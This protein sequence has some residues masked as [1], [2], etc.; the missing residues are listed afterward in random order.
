KGNYKSILYLEPVDLVNKY[1]PVSDVKPSITPTSSEGQVLDETEILSPLM[2]DNLSKSF[3]YKGKQGLL[4][5]TEDGKYAIETDTEIIEITKQGKTNV[6]PDASLFTLGLTPISII[7]DIGELIA[8]NDKVYRV[9]NLNLETDTVTINGVDYEIQRT[10][11]KKQVNGVAF[12]NNQAAIRILDEKISTLSDEIVER[13]ANRPEEESINDYTRINA[14]KIFELQ[15][16]TQDIVR[17]I[18]GNKRRVSTG[19]NVND[20]IFAINKSILFEAF[21]SDDTET[22]LNDLDELKKLFGSDATFNDLITLFEGAPA[23]LSKL[24]EQGI[25]AVNAEEIATINN[26]A[27]GTFLETERQSLINDDA[28]L[29]NALT[30]LS[31]LINNIK[32]VEL[33]KN[34]KIQAKAEGSEGSVPGASQSTVSKSGTGESTNVPGSETGTEGTSEEIDA[35]E[36]STDLSSES[37][38]DINQ[39]V[40]GPV[41]TQRN[42]K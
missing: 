5:Y 6:S 10:P 3:M 42:T 36:Q 33:N 24:F 39:K 25:D 37:I 14:T 7:D 16:L 9:T 18:E 23:A 8:I 17:L 15:Q 12:M 30:F 35:Q 13:R 34:G 11:K 26:W 29:Q 4:I 2:Q 40:L 41:N 31:N 19:G 22:R 32:L 38:Q 20:L 28:E 1:V 21:K 27:T